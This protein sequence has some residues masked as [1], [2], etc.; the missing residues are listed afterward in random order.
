MPL[1]PRDE[2]SGKIYK[3]PYDTIRSN[4]FCGW[5]VVKECYGIKEGS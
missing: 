3:S 5:G 4:D 1:M 2:Y